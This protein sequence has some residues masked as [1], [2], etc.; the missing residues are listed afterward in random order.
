MNITD[1]P[2]IF[3]TDYVAQ[4]PPIHA[5]R[6][7]FWIP[8]HLVNKIAEMEHESELIV[9]WFTLILPDH[10]SVGC[11]CALLHVL[12]AHKCEPHHPAIFVGR[13]GDRPANSAAK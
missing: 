7:V 12:A 8:N 9:C 13:C 4:S 10:P 5:L 6:T 1:L 11:R 3:E 2:A